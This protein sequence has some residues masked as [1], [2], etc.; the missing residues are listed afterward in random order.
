MASRGESLLHTNDKL[1]QLL[2]PDSIF[3]KLRRCK[4]V[5]TDGDAQIDVAD[6]I[7]RSAPKLFAILVCLTKGHLMLEFLEEGINDTHLP[8]ERTDKRGN[9]INF[10][11]CSKNH[12]KHPIKCMENWD[13]GD[14]INFYR[15]QWC[16]LAPVFDRGEDVLHQDLDDNC[17]LPFLEDNE[18]SDKARKGGFGFVWEIVIHPAHQKLHHSTNLEVNT[19]V[20]IF[21]NYFIILN[22]SRIR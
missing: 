6:N 19:N 21:A 17:I 2:T 22:S 7:S 3:M 15:D 11:L 12:P 1:Q 5:F 20:P 14:I 13:Q 10:K 16:V 9:S 18:R 8:F 4:L